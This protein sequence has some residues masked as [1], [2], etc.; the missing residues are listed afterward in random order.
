MRETID[1]LQKFTPE[2]IYLL[3]RRYNILRVISSNQPLGRRTLAEKLMLGER[4]VRGELDFFRKQQL[5]QIGT[6]GV[7]L[8]PE[9]EG[10]LDD[11]RNLVHK[12]QG[13]TSLEKRLAQST[14]LARVCI[15]PGDV[16]KDPTILKELG[17]LAGR[18]IRDTVRDNWIIAVTGGT[19]MAEVAANTP[20]DSGC[21]NVV[22][23]PARGGL[24]EDV[25]IQ[26][27]SVAALLARR[28]KAAY[29]LLHIPDS[30][31]GKLRAN[32]LGDDRIQEIVALSRKANLLMHGIGLPEVMAK[33]RQLAWQEMLQGTDKRPVGEVFGN[34]FAADGSVVMT[35]PTVGPS[36]EELSEMELVVA[37]AGGHSKAEAILAVLKNGFVKMLITDQGAA[38]KMEKVL[39]DSRGK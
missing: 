15:V 14:S 36:L 4:V 31:S 23:V 13:L 10:I 33:R 38:E 16:D 18:F 26:A 35:T 22:V 19:T 39:D 29:R 24:G 28:L 17:K 5:L 3:E 30:I 6:A 37:V 32:L 12:L 7:S 9:C 1:L 25:D 2:I 27:N 34:C 11:L 20:C 8:T 21:N